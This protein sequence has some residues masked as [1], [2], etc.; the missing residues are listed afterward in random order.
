MKMYLSLLLCATLI[1]YAGSAQEKLLVKDSFEDSTYKENWKSAQVCCSYS[2]QRSDSVARD[3][4]Y[5]LRVELHSTDPIVSKGKRAELT[6]SAIELSPAKWSYSFSTYLPVDYPTDP[7]YEIIAQWHEVADAHLGEKSRTPPISLQIQNGRWVLSIKWATD[8][9]NTS[10][11]LSGAKKIDLGEAA[12]N[13]W[14]DWKFIIYFSYKEDGYIELWKNNEP[15]VCYNGP[16]YYNDEMGPYFKIGLYKSQWKRSMPKLN[17]SPRVIY[18]DNILI[19]KS[20]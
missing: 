5:S 16:N 15:F 11:S 18:I 1:T 2:L 6:T 17:I 8:P 12:R 7:S 10:K 13:I 3:G 4:K 20:L 14:T 9:V 19:D